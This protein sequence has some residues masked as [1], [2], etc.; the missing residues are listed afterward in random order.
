MLLIRL[1]LW[2]YSPSWD[3]AETNG[4]NQGSNGSR[5]EPRDGPSDKEGRYQADGQADWRAMLWRA[6]HC[7]RLHRDQAVLEE[8]RKQVEKKLVKSLIRPIELVYLTSRGQYIYSNTL[9]S[10]ALDHI[11]SKLRFT[12]D[13]ICP[14]WHLPSFSKT[15]L[16]FEPLGLDP[17]KSLTSSLIICICIHYF[18]FPPD[19]NFCFLQRRPPIACFQAPFIAMHL[20]LQGFEYVAC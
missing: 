14:S 16:F 20:P 4:G 1:E 3:L 2:F 19:T 9:W 10:F 11:L 6:S 13:S 15:F 7:P 8:Y 17:F 18:C 5:D 12:S